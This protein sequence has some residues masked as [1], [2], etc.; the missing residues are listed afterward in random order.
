MPGVLCN[1][2]RLYSPFIINNKVVQGIYVKN[3]VLCGSCAFKL[4][5][6]SNDPKSRDPF[7]IGRI[8]NTKSTKYILSCRLFLQRYIFCVDL[9]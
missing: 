4:T 3:G 6:G 7:R 1:H 2:Q 8:K 9:G 5:N